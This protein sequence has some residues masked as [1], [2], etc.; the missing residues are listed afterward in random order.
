MSQ[1]R[2]L[3]IQ[4]HQLCSVQPVPRRGGVSGGQDARPKR[5]RQAPGT[6]PCDA[7]LGLSSG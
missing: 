1:P 4:R 6:C 3:Q 7:R 2:Q 5:G